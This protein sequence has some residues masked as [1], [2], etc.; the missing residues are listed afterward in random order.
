VGSVGAGV[1][2]AGLPVVSR[3]CIKMRAVDGG[4]PTR[5]SGVGK[6]GSTSRSRAARLGSRF[7]R[8][9]SGKWGSIA[10]SSSSTNGAAVVVLGHL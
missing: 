4:G 7:G 6:S 8:R 10:R 5:K 1:A 9:R 2:G 3:S